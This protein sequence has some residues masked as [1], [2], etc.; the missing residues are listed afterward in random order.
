MIRILIATSLLLGAL[1]TVSLAALPPFNTT[2]VYSQAAF[3]A[4]IKPYTEAIAK[5]ANDAEAH[6]W[7]G[8]AYLHAAQLFGFGLAPYASEFGP[9][10]VAS[11]ERA[12][13]LRPGFIPAHLALLNAY[14]VVGDFGGVGGVLDRLLTLAPPRLPK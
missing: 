13:K 7:L 1:T 8:V 5:N 2:R 12:V 10:A 3:M 6:Y 11:L 9:R 4:A 14:R